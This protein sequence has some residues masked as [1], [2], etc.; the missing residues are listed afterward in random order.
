MQRSK[1][2]LIELK[3]ERTNSNTETVRHYSHRCMHY[4]LIRTIDYRLVQ[5][6]NDQELNVTVNNEKTWGANF[7]WK[8][9]ER[10]IMV[11]LASCG[12]KRCL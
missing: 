11:E 2:P 3:R 8:N 5:Y 9:A 12:M 6:V 7:S 4:R 1:Q 10:A